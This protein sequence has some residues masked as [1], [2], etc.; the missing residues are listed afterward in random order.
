MAVKSEK[1][2]EDIA[3]DAV[4]NYGD[5]SLQLPHWLAP[6]RVQA[7]LL[8]VIAILF[9]CNTFRHDYALDDTAVIVRND[10]VHQGVAGIPD[11]MTKDV[12]YC[13]FNQVKSTDQL[14]GGR[15]RPLSVV[16]FALEQQLF[17]A[18][19]RDAT[20]SII[21]YGLGYEMKEHYEQHFLSQ[22]HFRHVVNVLIYALLA[23]AVLY[24]LRFV[25]FP[26]QP[27]LA[28][29]AATI[30]IIHPIHTEVV[31]NVKSRDELLSLL[32]IC[33]TFISAFRFLEL[34]KWWWLLLAMAFYF[35]AF[36]SKEYAITLLVLLPL[37]FYLF[38]RCTIRRSIFASLPY[39]AI[40][41]IYIAIRLQVI[42][43]GNDA[44]SNDIQ[45]NPYAKAVGNEKVATEVATSL[46]YLKLLVFPH[47]LSSDYS[48]NQIPYKN[49]GDAI[50]WVS[51]AVYL[52]LI[53]AFVYFLIRRS[54]LAFAIAFYLVN[55]AMICNLVFD[56]GATMGERLI[57][58]AS[59]GFAIAV[60]YLLVKG[61]ERLHGDRQI[62]G[63]LAVCMAGVIVLSGFKT[64]TRNKDWKND[65]SLFMQDIN[66][67]PNSFLVNVNVAT[68][69]INRSD[70]ERDEATRV[71]NVKR[72]VR[73]YTHVIEM[74][75][76]YVLG[77][78]NRCVA[79]YKLGMADSM[80]ADLNKVMQLYPIYPTLPVMY[81]HAATVYFRN[82]QYQQAEGAV[83]QS[84]KLDPKNG[85]A[86]RLL[87]DIRNALQP[88]K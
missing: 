43:V 1:K 55:W 30:F 36:L 28:L 40:A 57:F 45:I 78:M 5:G 51:I 54:V 21:Q 60:A 16:T 29:I 65:E 50:V 87:A 52:F 70:F 53:L 76:D 44:P 37:S 6:F 84:L 80:V 19:P 63:V 2:S 82:K 42:G 75:P 81:F 15:Y 72:G 69:L 32:F 86:Q 33:L 10:F 67:S 4:T 11:I 26:R 41:L 34:K 9:Y 39:L 27:L 73:L 77:Y 88:P 35:L 8:V 62:W 17:G 20:D 48:Y 61:V 25:V 31:A 58:H 46:N 12:Y 14:T 83:M 59:L 68:L 49:F 47:P 18:V 56:I 71:N 24:M 64:I 7:G 38:G 23:V 3:T 13:F 22:M 79:Y 74:Q 85:D 66:T